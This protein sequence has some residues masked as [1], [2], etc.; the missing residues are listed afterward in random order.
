MSA[1]TPASTSQTGEASILDLTLIHKIPDHNPRTLR[2][3]TRTDDMRESIRTNGVLQPI[4]VRPHPDLSGEY[5]LVAG[6]TRFDLCR[7]VGHTTIPALIRL[8]DDADLLTMA[9]LENVVRQDMSVMDE[10]NAAKAMMIQHGDKDAVCKLLGWSRSK[11]DGRIQLTHCI[12]AVAEALVNDDIAIGHAQLLS[13]LRP[14]S[15]QNAL[16]YVLDQKLSVEG[17]KALIDDMA[18]NLANAI[19]DTAECAACPHNSSVQTSLF[20]AGTADGRCLNKACFDSKTQDRLLVIKS[21]LD[22]SFHTVAMDN[23]VAQGTTAIIATTGGTGVGSEQVAECARCEHFGALVGS[24]VGREGQVTR[25]V[26]FNTGC[27]T[28]K[29][30]TYQAMI[31]TESNP[32][33]PQAS[34]SDTSP[35]AKKATAKKAKAASD[36]TPKSVLALHHK[37]KRTVAGDIAANDQRLATIVAILSLLSDASIRFKT[38]PEGWPSSLTGGSRA[39]AAQVLDAMSDDDLRKLQLQLTAKVLREANPFG[40]DANERDTFGSVAEWVTK[41]RDCDLRDYFVV[42]AEYLQPYTKPVIEQILT[43]SGFASDYDQRQGDGAFKKLVVGKKGEILKAV[44]ESDFS[45]KGYLPK[46]LRPE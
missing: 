4:L 15:Q 8:I 23:E 33:P 38:A 44:S 26:C 28:E 14:E 40:A 34:I 42:D 10:G 27:H 36:A 6:E 30:K 13:G 43:E 12:N 16:T 22:E 11:L 21:E 41:S 35:S 46:G 25:N 39:V 19:F 2:S 20:D 3:K 7:E 9:T 18:L 1:D 45:F 24:Q 29:V 31:A 17:L 32:A 5:Q 37:V